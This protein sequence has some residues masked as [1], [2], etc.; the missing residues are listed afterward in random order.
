MKS[1]KLILIIL[2][3][4]QISC[5]YKIANNVNDYNF[6][7]L[8]YQLSGERK[9]NNILERNFKRFQKNEK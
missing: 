6:N 2:L 9:V 3:F 1:S 5:G 8:K 4:S 7:I